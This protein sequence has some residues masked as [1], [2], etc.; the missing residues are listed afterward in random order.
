[1]NIPQ[2]IMAALLALGVVV[3]FFK[4]GKEMPYNGLTALLVHLPIVLTLL[5]WGGFF[6]ALGAAQVVL[7]VVMTMNVVTAL[8]NHGR[9]TRKYNFLLALVDTPITAGI[10]YWGGFW[11]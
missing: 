5:V 3:H 11:G 1:M 8:N 2:I 7:I 6:A 4:D 9:R 10:L